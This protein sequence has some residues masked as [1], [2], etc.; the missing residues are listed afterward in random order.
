MKLIVSKAEMCALF[1]KRSKSKLEKEQWKELQFKSLPSLPAGTVP[2]PQGLSSGC[3]G[4]MIPG[5]KAV[6][7]QGYGYRRRWEGQR[8]TL[9]FEII[10]FACIH[11][12]F[13]TCS[14]CDQLFGDFFSMFFPPP[15]WA[16]REKRGEKAQK[17]LVFR[18]SCSRLWMDNGQP[19]EGAQ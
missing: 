12:V 6:A 2:K 9:R 3:S 18:M 11:L 1:E 5:A 13:G 8:F 15:Y 10:S 7:W 16:L 4:T 17:C 19:R 14:H